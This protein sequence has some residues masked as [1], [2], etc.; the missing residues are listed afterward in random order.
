VVAAGAI[1]RFAVTVAI[2]FPSWPSTQSLLLQPVSFLFALSLPSRV[3]VSL[4]NFFSVDPSKV[5]VA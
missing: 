5:V 3:K 1:Y 4:P 2:D